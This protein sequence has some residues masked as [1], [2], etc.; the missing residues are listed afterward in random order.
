MVVI[1]PAPT[2]FTRVT[3]ERIGCPSRCT[4]HAPHN[5]MPQPN[6]VPVRPSVSRST[7]SNG[8]S[9]STSTSVSLPLTLSLIIAPPAPENPAHERALELA[10]AHR[11]R[12]RYYTAGRERCASLP[13]LPGEGSCE[14]AGDPLQC[15]VATTDAK[16]SALSQIPTHTTPAAPITTEAVIIGAGP[17]GLFQVFELGLLGISAHVVDSLRH[18][19]GQCAELYPDKPIY[20]IPA[21]PVCGAQEL[22]D[23]LMQQIRPFKPQLHLGHEVVEFARRETGRFH[24]R[25]AGGVS[26]DAG[27]VVI[28]AGVGSFQARRIGLEGAD[29]FEGSTI[30]Y[31]VKS[32]A[33]LAGKHLVIF[34]GG[35]SAPASVARMQG[36]VAPARM[37]CVEAL[38]HSLI[39]ND[40]GLRGV[41]IRTPD[42]AL[43]A[44]AADQ[45]LVF[46]G[47]HP[48]LGPIAEWGLA[49][50]KKALT[51][52][53]EKFQTSLPGVFAVGDI[54]VYPGKKKLILSGFHEAALAAFAIQHHLYP[55]KKQFLQYTTTSPVMHKRLGVPD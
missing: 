41:N 8:M 15:L 20:D 36:Q 5:A 50:E 51:V 1:F 28:A 55:Q 3:H 39:V 40:G 31:R 13:P 53:T 14:G 43:E 11:A 35:D 42:G 30:Q 33:E 24:L 21:L 26:F 6:L 48:K 4:V 16:A 45:L 27:T 44:L 38:P 25:T 12:H 17:C 23:R 34:G 10:R 29:A 22:V 47:L 46:F 49:L 18:P 32:A 52:D 2:A 19:G 7:H 54:N 37:R 9:G